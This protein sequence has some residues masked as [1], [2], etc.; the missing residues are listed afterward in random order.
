MHTT[1]LNFCALLTSAVERAAQPQIAKITEAEGSE[2]NTSSN[3]LKA[4]A[5]KTL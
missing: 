5:R 1:I 2:I 4:D 3:Q